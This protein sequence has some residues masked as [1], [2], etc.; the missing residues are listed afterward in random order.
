MERLELSLFFSLSWFS[1]SILRDIKSTIE[2]KRNG[3]QGCGHLTRIQLG[4]GLAGWGRHQVVRWGHSNHTPP[5][6]SLSCFLCCRSWVINISYYCN[7]SCLFLPLIFYQ[8]LLCMIS[9][10]DIWPIYAHDFYIFLV[11]WHFCHVMY[12]ILT[13]VFHFKSVFGVILA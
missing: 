13:R 11:K 8:H 6:S 5:R 10:G 4:T 2:Y 3:D 1:K 12:L 9:C 7:R